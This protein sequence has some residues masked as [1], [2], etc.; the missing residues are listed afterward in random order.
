M[1]PRLRPKAGVDQCPLSAKRGRR[2]VSG[3]RGAVDAEIPKTAPLGLLPCVVKTIS[4]GH[5][6]SQCKPR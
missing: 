1:Q 2:E 6:S 3:L 5:R 4:P